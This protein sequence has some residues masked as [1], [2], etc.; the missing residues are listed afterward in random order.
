MHTQAHTTTTTTT[1]TIPATAT[2]RPDHIGRIS[3]Y[4]ASWATDRLWVR[5]KRTARQL[6]AMPYSE[7]VESREY[8]LDAVRVPSAW[9][10]GSTAGVVAGNHGQE[11]CPF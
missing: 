9:G 10:E 4:E 6:A 3:C 2:V 7:A 1:P 8:R 5:S 11:T